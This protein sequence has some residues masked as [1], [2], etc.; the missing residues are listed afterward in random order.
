VQ[1]SSGERRS[2]END[3]DAAKDEVQRRPARTAVDDRVADKNAPSSSAPAG[4]PHRESEFYAA[5]LETAARGP[6]ALEQAARSAIAEDG[7]DCRKVAALRALRDSRCSAADEILV[8]AIAD[9]PDA[10]G[11]NKESVPRFALR[12]LVDRA[13]CDPGARRALEQVAWNNR[14]P[15]GSALR[16]AA[17]AALAATATENEIWRVTDRLRSE[18]EALVFDGAVEALS[19]NPQV[20]AASAALRSLGLETPLRDDNPERQE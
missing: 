5:F 16:A 14:K 3:L 17:A 18:T 11:P 10:S 19:R 9:L 7:P 2:A 1:V 12:T 13:P 15:T 20:A 6:L 8:A 4:T